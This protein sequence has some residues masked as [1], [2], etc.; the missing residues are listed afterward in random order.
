MA[1][2]LCA[3]VSPDSARPA[4]DRR[5]SVLALSV[6]CTV[7]LAAASLGSIALGRASLAS[8]NPPDSS[9]STAS[10][11]P[12]MLDD[13]LDTDEYSTT[14]SPADAV[15]SA[16]SWTNLTAISAVAAGPPALVG[17]RAG[18]GPSLAWDVAT[19][20]TILLPGDPT[21]SPNPPPTSTWSYS[22][23][24]WTNLSSTLHGRPPNLNFSALAYDPVLG[25]ML[26]FGGASSSGWLNDIWELD[27]GSWINETP[28]LVTA[29]PAIEYPAMAWDP[30]AS[31]MLLVG[32]TGELG[33]GPKQTWMFSDG[34]WSN[35]SVSLPLASS[36][37]APVMT[38]DPAVGGVLLVDADDNEAYHPTQTFAFADGS[39]V[40]LSSPSGTGPSLDPVFRPAVAYVG[41][42]LGA[43]LTSGIWLISSS[44]GSQVSYPQTWAYN[45]DSWWNLTSAVGRSPPYPYAVM[46]SDP[47]DDSLLLFGGV[48]IGASFPS[49][50]TWA[51]SAPPDLQLNVTPTSMD[52]GEGVTVDTNV[53]MGLDPNQPVLD[54]GDGTTVDAFQGTHSYGSAGV[55]SVTLTASDRAGVTT[56][57]SQG[58]EVNPLPTVSVIAPPL[59][60]AEQ[61]V[62][63]VASVSGGTPPF[64]FS[65]SLGDGLVSSSPDPQHTYGGSGSY[66]IELQVEDSDSH[67]ANSTLTVLVAAA[68]PAPLLGNL[69]ALAILAGLVATSALAVAFAVVWIR[70]RQRK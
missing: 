63:F 70:A 57:V 40:N 48:A 27:G 30:N 14:V 67:L 33:L 60:R 52:V 36:S 6:V 66:T 61:P 16:Y 23:G 39:W 2:S 45:N 4:L 24:T 35:L 29:P 59:I 5:A 21:N 51:L 62:T 46:D 3:A 8:V 38:T 1:P 50:E 11:V 17:Q 54:W 65:W 49:N 28:P 44:S 26:L 68:A 7:V 42:T 15:A 43:V 9:L 69:A 37:V 55:F 64:S 20:S 58:I 34:M 53:S 13:R 31:A 32:A 19:N 41:G 25:A 18:G 12:P 56:V 10:S 22:N 47:Q